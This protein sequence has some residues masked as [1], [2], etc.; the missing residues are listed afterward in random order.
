MTSKYCATRSH[1]YSQHYV[2]VSVA[3]FSVLAE[4]P[5]C[6]W[7]PMSDDTVPDVLEP[8][9]AKRLARLG[10]TV[11][12]K[13]IER[14]DEI[15]RLHAEGGGIREIARAVGLNPGTVHNIIN[16]RRR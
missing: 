14:N 9:D 13:T 6:T 11:T 16:G 8:D 7:F 10:K 3:I 5:R 1:R 12:D 2:R 15:K 4:S